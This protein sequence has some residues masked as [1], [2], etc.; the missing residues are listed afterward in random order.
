MIKHLSIGLLYFNKALVPF[1]QSLRGMIDRLRQARLIETL[2][3]PTTDGLA[4]DM[5]RNLVVKNSLTAGA[6]AVVW[7]DT[8]MIYPT[9]TLIK[10][11]NYANA[12]NPI[13]AGLYRR[14]RPPY[15]VL[16][17]LDWGSFAEIEDIDAR[18]NGTALVS[19]AMTAGGFSIVK[20]E[21]YEAVPLPWYCNWD[22]VSGQGPVGE[23]RFFLLR[24][25]EAGFKPVVDP[26]L[27]AVHC[28]R[29][30]IPVRRDDGNEKSDR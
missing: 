23:D 24:A 20:R 5:A 3:M 1:E 29:S 9:D 21:V 4:V 13:V 16:T 25:A 10:L 11:V 27:T 28:G 15:E 12:G 14:T 6:D 30:Y 17:E 2:Q 19:V 7:L 8:D 26:D 18:R 22:F